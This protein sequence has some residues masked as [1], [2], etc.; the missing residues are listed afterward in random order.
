MLIVSSD[1]VFVQVMGLPRKRN[2][3]GRWDILIDKSTKC[4][5][6][7]LEIA[8]KKKRNYVLDQVREGAGLNVR[9]AGLNVR[10]ACLNLFSLQVLFHFRCTA[11]MQLYWG[12][13]VGRCN[14]KGDFLCM[15]L[16]RLQQD[17]VIMIKRQLTL[18]KQWICLLGSDK[19]GFRRQ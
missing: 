9:G 19:D 6:R 2:Y 18:S 4:L 16:C 7:L 15:T 13:F 5:N 3:S 12:N 1:A 11:Y 14:K 17:N 8:S 10:G